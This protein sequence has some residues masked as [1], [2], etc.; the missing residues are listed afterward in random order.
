[1]LI[2][3]VDGCKD[4]WVIV[5]ETHEGQTAIDVAPDFQQ[6]L[7]SECDLIVVDVPIGLLERGTR[8][9]DQEA[10][11]LL[12]A[13][14]CCVFTAPLRPMLT[15]LDYLE[16]RKCRLRIEGKSLTKQ[17]WAIMPKIIEVDRLLT[18]KSQSRVREGHPEL[19][20]AH[21]NDGNALGLSKHSKEGRQ[22]RIALLTKHFSGIASDVQKHSRV[23]QDLVDAYA[24]LW[25]ARRIR[26]GGAV[27][28][29]EHAPRDTHRLLMQIWA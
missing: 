18:S 6:I 21:L 3:G 10:R 28:L 4:G 5:S 13:R 14:A 23:A 25:T 1:M 9:A 29:A 16:A 15:C 17:A 12:K 8:L 27:A 24:M 22:N 2:A 11:R 20:F 7:R 26:D 19:S